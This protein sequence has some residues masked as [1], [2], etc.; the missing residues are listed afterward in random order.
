MTT[1]NLGEGS[2]DIEMDVFEQES[3]NEEFIEFAVRESIQDA[4]KVACST[5]T[6]R[7]D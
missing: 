4:Y 1:N 3:I 6:N 2:C 5:Q 7:Y